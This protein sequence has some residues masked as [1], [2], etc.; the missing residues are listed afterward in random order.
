MI[1]SSVAETS[2]P[3]FEDLLGPVATEDF[4]TRYWERESLLLTGRPDRARNCITFRDVETLAYSLQ[5]CNRDWLRLIKDGKELPES[6]YATRES[7]VDLAKVWR[8]YHAG[9]TLQL[10][11]M[12]KRWA[13][14]A[15]ICRGIEQALV[16]AGLLLTTRT[17]AHLYLTPAGTQGFHTHYDYHDVFVLQVEGSKHWHVHEWTGN[18]PLERRA[19]TEPP[20]PLPPL[21]H[22]VVLRPGD[23]LYIPRGVHHDARATDEASLHITFSVFPATWVDLIQRLVPAERA[24]RAPLPRGLAGRQGDL[25]GAAAALGERLRSLSDAGTIAGGARQIVEDY[26][27]AIDATPADGLLPWAAGD[28]I[29]AESPLQ[30]RP[31]ML[32]CSLVEGDAARLVFQGSALKGPAPLSVTFDFIATH[33]RFTPADLPGPLSIDMKLHVVRALVADGLLMPQTAAPAPPA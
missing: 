16:S 25:A 3:I 14:V 18:Y 32:A 29:G 31:G 19:T 4:L 21:K 6:S 8:A 13:P 17:G 33:D 22:D 26:L 15:A 2:S 23:L 5:S 28:A 12:H 1:A 10:S 11:K 7:M 27:A 20:E 9:Y 30:K 24:L